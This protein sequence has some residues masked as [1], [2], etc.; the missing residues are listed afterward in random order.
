LEIEI[1]QEKLERMKKV[2]SH[3]LSQLIQKV[4]AHL[5][6]SDIDPYQAAFY[7]HFQTRHPEQLLQ[8]I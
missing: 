2:I 3:E 4:E 6:D 8:D 5:R 7:K 1:R